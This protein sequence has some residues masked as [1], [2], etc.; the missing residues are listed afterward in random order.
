MLSVLQQTLEALPF[1]FLHKA[2]SQNILTILIDEHPQTIAMVLSYLP[3]TLAAGVLGGL[4]PQRQ[5][6]VIERIAEMSQT[7]PEAIEEV[8]RALSNRMALFM[9]QAYQ[10]VGGAPAVAENSQRQ[11]SL[12]GTQHLRWTDQEQRRPGGR[13]PSI[14]VRL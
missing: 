5:L 8:E 2:D 4:N 6:A 7:S 13:D 1:G 11:R 3:P 12:H 9:T 10:K 14:D